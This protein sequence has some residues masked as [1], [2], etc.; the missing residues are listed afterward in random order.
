M[1]QKTVRMFALFSL[2][3]LL[4]MNGQV[5]PGHASGVLCSTQSGQDF[6]PLP[7]GLHGNMVDL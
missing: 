1:A 3:T 6:E 5:Y 7:V 4:C 2:F